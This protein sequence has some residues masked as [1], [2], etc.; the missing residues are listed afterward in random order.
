M[1]LPL[2]E[3]KTAIGRHAEFSAF[4]QQATQRFAHWRT[5]ATQRLR[6]FGADAH[7]KE[8]I[9]ALSE[10]LLTAF[11][12][13]PLVDAY[14][15]YQHLMDYWAETMQDDAYLIAADGWVAKTSRI[16]DT[17]KK[18]KTKDRGWTCELIPKPLI[19]A[20]CFA[21][22]QAALDTAQADLEAATAS[23]AELEEDRKSVV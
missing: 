5:A 15:I 17:D 9:A 7:P 2:A 21:K 20:R 23:L 6:G 16:L 10:D 1:K 18:G 19:V 4:N 8:L 14:D 12:D 13:V 22:E 11:A 3:L